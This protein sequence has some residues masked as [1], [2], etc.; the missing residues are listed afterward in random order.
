[1]EV[2]CRKE[3]KIDESNLWK[4]VMFY[5][6]HSFIWIHFSFTVHKDSSMECDKRWEL[7]QVCTDGVPKLVWSARYITLY[8]WD[9]EGEIERVHGL[10][11]GV[12]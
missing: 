12:E 4:P 10:K 3:I 6:F 2:L 11:L 5:L 1:M 9:N 8:H 7:A